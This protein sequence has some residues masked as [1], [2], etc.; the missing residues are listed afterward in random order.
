MA[1][2]HRHDTA[3]AVVDPGLPL[4]TRET[5]HRLARQHPRLLR[6]PAAPLPYA[7]GLD[8]TELAHGTV[9]TAG[10]GVLLAVVLLASR[11][12]EPAVLAPWPGTAVLPWIAGAMVCVCEAVT[13]LRARV[14]GGRTRVAEDLA[15]ARGRYLLRGE[16]LPAESWALVARATQTLERVLIQ[17][18]L[19]EPVEPDR[20]ALAQGVWSMARA[21]AAGAGTAASETFVAALELYDQRIHEAT[22]AQL[23]SDPRSPELLHAIDRAHDAGRHALAMAAAAAH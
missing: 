4:R 7:A 1:I 18:W 10:M 5:I 6:D 13:L 23:T 15:E 3:H 19:G 9:V 20:D 17:T 22:K 8:L 16:Q 11:I 21:L 14:P 12:P 2:G